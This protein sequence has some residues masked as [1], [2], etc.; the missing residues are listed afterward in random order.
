MDQVDR[1]GGGEFVSPSLLGDKRV[2]R[3][4]LLDERMGLLDLIAHESL[5]ECNIS[6]FAKWVDGGDGA[7]MNDFAEW[8]K[9][10]REAQGAE[11]ARAKR[12]LEDARHRAA[13]EEAGRR[14]FEEMDKDASGTL[15]DRELKV[16]LSRLGRRKATKKQVAASHAEM[17]TDGSG[18]V[19]MD[20]FIAWWC[21]VDEEQRSLV[22]E[23]Q[24]TARRSKVKTS[25]PDGAKGALRTAS[26][27]AGKTT[28]KKPR[29]KKA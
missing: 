12:A 18:E 9:Q 14:V 7:I 23:A 2:A 29:K 16:L 10:A 19:S 20:E 8:D 24:A 5:R 15:D 11:E 3:K 26:S 6:T 22:V 4:D 25:D 27:H 13:E 17:D 1:H 28:K 21:Q